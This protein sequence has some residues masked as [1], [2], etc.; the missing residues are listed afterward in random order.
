MQ[1]RAIWT[2]ATAIQKVAGL[3]SAPAGIGLDE[4]RGDLL[5]RERSAQLF[6]TMFKPFDEGS[7]PTFSAGPTLR[8]KRISGL[9]QDSR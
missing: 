3:R 5:F 4:T 6:D 8:P 2:R 1:L 9:S 7:S